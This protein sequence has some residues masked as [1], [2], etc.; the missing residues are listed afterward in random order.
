MRSG[1]GWWICRNLFRR[2]ASIW[3]ERSCSAWCG[4]DGTLWF[5]AG[6]GSETVLPADF[7]K[8]KS[9]PCPA[10]L[11]RTTGLALAIQA[12]LVQAIGNLSATFS[13]DHRSASIDA[14][15]LSVRGCWGRSFVL[16]AA[17][18]STLLPEN[19]TVRSADHSDLSGV[20]LILKLCLPFI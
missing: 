12:A 5:W 1:T 11:A 18:L 15:P 7:V 8:T 14:N 20:N 4:A 3:S 13:G 16:C 17:L 6:R 10:A 2:T 19:P 9:V